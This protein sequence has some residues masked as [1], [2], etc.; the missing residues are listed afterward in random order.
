MDQDFLD[1]N[2]SNNKII[3]FIIVIILIL[4]FLGY[5]FVYSK[6]KFALKTI[7]HEIG[8][9]L[10]TD[11]NDY[12]FSKIIDTSGY[13]LDISKVKIDEVGEYEYRVKYNRVYKTG[14]IIVADTTPPTFSVKEK[15]EIEEEDPNF[16]LS[17]TLSS[18]NDMSMPCFV[19]LKDDSDEDKLNTPGEYKLDIVIEDLYNNKET[20]EVYIKVYE[21]GTLVR[22]EEKDLTL[23]SS[24]SELPSFNDE[25]YVKFE[26]AIKDDTDKI[27]DTIAEI[28]IDLIEEYVQTNYPNH[29]LTNAEIVKM[30]NKSNYVIGLVIK[31]TINN[32]SDKVIYMKK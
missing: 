14:K 16:Y 7:K 22:D 5:F 32:G 15:V 27:E 2:K 9:P 28:T 10:S 6:Y 25:Y 13:K 19:S 20:A 1:V 11:V 31:L 4:I 26:R 18:C 12:L 17:D 21:K 29:K 30:Y 23:F 3:A 24:S 8:T